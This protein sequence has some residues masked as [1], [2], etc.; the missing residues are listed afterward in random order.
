MVALAGARGVDER[1]AVRRQRRGREDKNH[2]EE[3]DELFHISI[4][5]DF[6][7]SKKAGKAQ[8]KAMQRAA[9]NGAERGGERMKI[10]IVGKPKEIAALAAE[11]QERQFQ[12]TIAMQMHYETDNFNAMCKG[13]KILRAVKDGTSD[14]APASE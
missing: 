2:E 7:Y 3:A 12:Q 5:A 9:P 10:V 11:T 13:M 1:G 4:T 6:Y 8:H 14:L